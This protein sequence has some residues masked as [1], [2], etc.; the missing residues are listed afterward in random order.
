MPP[1]KRILYRKGLR[2]PD[3]GSVAS[4]TSSA[5]PPLRRRR[6]DDDDDG[7][8]KDGT[9]SRASTP[10]TA[11][12]SSS[13]VQ[14]QKGSVVPNGDSEGEGDAS[15]SAGGDDDI[16]DEEEAFENEERDEDDDDDGAPRNPFR[17]ASVLSAGGSS[18]DELNLEDDLMDNDEDSLGRYAF[19]FSHGPGHF[20]PPE[21]VDGEETVDGAGAGAGGA[22]GHR[23][24]NGAG[25]GGGPPRATLGEKRRSSTSSTASLGRKLKGAA[26]RMREARMDRRRR[27]AQRMLALQDDVGQ[28]R[29]LLPELC[30]RLEMAFASPWCDLTERGAVVVIAAAAGLGLAYRLMGDAEERARAKRVLL[31]VGVPLIVFRLCW[32]LIYWAAWGRHVERRRRARMDIYDG[33][34]GEH[35]TQGLEIPTGETGFD[36]GQREEGEHGRLTKD[37]V[38][39]DGGGGMGLPE[40][41]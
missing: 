20:D 36:S 7:G 21:Y 2:A 27:R 11:D 5:S 22:S 29:G 31:A 37:A 35:G 8:G 14:I 30:R 39:H 24:S 26:R 28:R 6:Q 9:A 41:L 17:I 38:R 1:K 13:A 10:T 15:G 34:N 32:R 19:D 33:L 3:G 12:A 18:F 40:V 25:R 16:D 4:A 23:G